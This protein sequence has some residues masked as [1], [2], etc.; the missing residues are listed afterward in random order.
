MGTS[1][2]QICAGKSGV[3]RSIDESL[4]SVV[5]ISFGLITIPN[6]LLLWIRSTSL[7]DQLLFALR[8]CFVSLYGRVF[9]ILGRV[10][11]VC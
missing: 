5:F 7:F 6:S 11:A 2:W 4:E 10:G 9:C 1:V 8:N 3:R